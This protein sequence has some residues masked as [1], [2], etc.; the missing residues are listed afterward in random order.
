[1][2]SNEKLIKRSP[3]ST[4]SMNPKVLETWIN[5]TLTDAEHLEIPGLLLKP[6]HKNPVSRYEI[7]RLF[8][9]N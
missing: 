8:L 9:S 5:E 4:K 6:S 2:P 7:D 1:M 3:K